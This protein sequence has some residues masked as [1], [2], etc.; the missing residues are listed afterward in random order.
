MPR[1]SFSARALPTVALAV[2][3]RRQERWAK[4]ERSRSRP[5]DEQ[6]H[7][8]LE[9]A[10]RIR[11]GG[12]GVPRRGAARHRWRDSAGDRHAHPQ[13]RSLSFFCSAGN[14]TSVNRDRTKEVCCFVIGGRLFAGDN[15]RRSVRAAPFAGRRSAIDAP[16]WNRRSGGRL[17]DC[18]SSAFE[19]VR[20]AA[21]HNRV[22][23]FVK[24]MMPR[25]LSRTLSQ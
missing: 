15:P 19:V 24:I 1:S 21:A 12:R 23:V 22:L 8:P 9:L 25:H 3:H 11:N 18:P 16:P 20:A 7:A 2:G 13:C 10:R 14:M 17:T 5:R 6:R 4:H